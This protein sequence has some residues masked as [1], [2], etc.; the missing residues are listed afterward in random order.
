MA[1]TCEQELVLRYPLHRFQEVM[2]QSKTSTARTHLRIK[3][4]NLK[5]EALPNGN[6]LVS[7]RLVQP[8]A[9]FFIC[10]LQN[11]QNVNLQ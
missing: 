5:C 2:L 9:I 11:F 7:I 10:C 1:C 6:G 8:F 4:Q 3:E